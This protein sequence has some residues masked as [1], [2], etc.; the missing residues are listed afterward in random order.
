MTYGRYVSVAAWALGIA[1]CTPA[2][3]AKNQN[4]DI[5]RWQ[6]SNGEVHFGQQQFAPTRADVH[7]ENVKVLPANSMDVP[8]NTQQGRRAVGPSVAVVEHKVKTNPRGFRGY[9]RRHGR[10]NRR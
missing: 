3:F 4:T 10:A 8:V 7:V 6:D 2:A 5:V 9:N 1:I